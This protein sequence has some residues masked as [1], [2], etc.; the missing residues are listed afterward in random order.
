[1]E[2]KTTETKKPLL[3][4]NYLLSVYEFFTNPFDEYSAEN[5]VTESKPY[6]NPSKY[7]EIE[8][9]KKLAPN[10]RE[11]IV[12]KLNS[13]F[14]NGYPNP[15]GY[16]SE[17]LFGTDREYCHCGN[18]LR[19]NR[20]CPVCNVIRYDETKVVRRKSYVRLPYP[21]FNPLY[22]QNLYSLI[23][24]GKS[25]LKE[26]YENGGARFYRFYLFNREKKK[27]EIPPFLDWNKLGTKFRND[28][29][30]LLDTVRYKDLVREIYDFAMRNELT[31]L[32]KEGFKEYIENKYIIEFPVFGYY[33]LILSIL[34]NDEILETYLSKFGAP[35]EAIFSILIT[36]PILSPKLRPVITI[37]S[38]T[39]EDETARYLRPIVSF[40]EKYNADKKS[41]ISRGKYK[42]D[43]TALV[44]QFEK[45][46]FTNF[47]DDSYLDY[48]DRYA[49]EGIIALVDYAKNE[50]LRELEKL[51]AHD[52]YN[53]EKSA[54]HLQF[55]VEKYFEHYIEK[56]RGKEGFVRSYIIGKTIDFSGR[57]V[58]TPT[59]QVPPYQILLPQKIA[60]EIFKL[61]FA[62]F[63]F[64]IS[65][66]VIKLKFKE[67]TDKYD[68]TESELQSIVNFKLI[69]G[70]TFITNA[71]NYFIKHELFAAPK[72]TVDR[73]EREN[74]EKYINYLF[75]LFIKNVNKGKIDLK[76]FINRQPTL[77]IYSIIA[78][79]VRINPNPDDNTI[80]INPLIQT[81][82]NADYDGDSVSKCIVKFYKS[83]DDNDSIEVFFD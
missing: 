71:Q 29:I 6:L 33:T 69:D 81:S 42:N 18:K 53:S 68:I 47:I 16:Y 4:L 77:W 12:K 54:R 60:R 38:Q 55:Y 73:F 3:P 75:K 34:A 70:G 32:D 19:I 10:K 76:A 24:G 31:E 61:E 56:L 43:E 25:A 36:L 35:S 72:H 37:G 83:L 23:V 26:L 39:F 51:T 65:K 82:F 57:A 74:Y 59:I 20:R 79:D 80:K 46:I 62:K 27:F 30:Q 1:M 58:I 52:L 50:Y 8:W 21:V 22:Y 78:Y 13:L 44:F 28:F 14:P 63:M 66:A 67:I 5:C 15:N 2:T 7:A 11:E 45:L 49:K 41:K 64:D 48:Y 17:Q 9:V 40:Y